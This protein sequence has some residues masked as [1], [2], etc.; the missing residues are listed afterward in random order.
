M[1]ANPVSA[2]ATIRSDDVR[3][4]GSRRRSYSMMP[5]AW[6]GSV[7]TLRSASGRRIPSRDAR[8]RIQDRERDEVQVAGVG[9]RSVVVDLPV[10]DVADVRGLGHRIGIAEPAVVGGAEKGLDAAVGVVLLAEDEPTG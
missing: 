5:T 10:F 8:R 3:P 1:S 6:S 2:A 7:P 9:D 4:T